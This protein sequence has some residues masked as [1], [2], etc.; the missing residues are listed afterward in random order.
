GSSSRAKVTRRY[1]AR[2]AARLTDI[3]VLGGDA[4]AASSGVAV[5]G[6]RCSLD[7]STATADQ[8]EQRERVLWRSPSRPRLSA[9]SRPNLAAARSRRFRRHTA[10]SRSTTPTPSK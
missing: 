3:H 9:S 10:N 1:G 2:A 8:T 5:V 6:G 4:V 7:A